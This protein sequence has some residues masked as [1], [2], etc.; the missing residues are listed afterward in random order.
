M[1]SQEEREGDLPLFCRFYGA[2]CQGLFACNEGKTHLG[3]NG[4]VV[5]T[6]LPSTLNAR[7]IEKSIIAVLRRKVPAR[8]SHCGKTWRIFFLSV[9]WVFFLQDCCGSALTRLGWGERNGK[10]AGRRQK[11][12]EN[13]GRIFHEGMSSGIVLW[14]LIRKISI[15]ISGKTQ[16]GRSRIVP[17]GI[18]DFSPSPGIGKCHHSGTHQEITAQMWKTWL[19]IPPKMPWKNTPA[20][21]LCPFT[22]CN[23]KR[24]FP[25]L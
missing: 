17:V 2:P 20:S 9:F 8:V 11:W 25:S 10:G 4:S 21:L 6:P 1:R 19:K 22:L 14:A 24:A 15:R 7:L 13:L 23:P 5:F 18:R 16:W 3:L 12:W